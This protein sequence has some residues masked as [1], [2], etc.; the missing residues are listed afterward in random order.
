MVELE[1]IGSTAEVRR[2]SQNVV[3]ADFDDLQII[4]HQKAAYSHIKMKT[5]KAVWNPTDIEY[6]SG[7]EAEQHFAA[8]FVLDYEEG[9]NMALPGVQHLW[10]VANELLQ[11][12]VD[13]TASPGAGTESDQIERTT[14]RD[15]GHNPDVRPPNKLKQFRRG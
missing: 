13:S 11:T 6:H 1:Y 7:V 12:I 8:V 10:T 14:W 4:P 2:L 3:E 15:W 9:I 5:G